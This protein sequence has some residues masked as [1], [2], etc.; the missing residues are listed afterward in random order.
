MKKKKSILQLDNY[1]NRNLRK[2]SR[3]NEKPLNI[4]N[5]IKKQN[6]FNQ[7]LF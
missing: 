4:S 7:E 2:E 6:K 3:K 1:A 5:V